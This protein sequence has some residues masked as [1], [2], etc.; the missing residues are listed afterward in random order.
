MISYAKMGSAQGAAKY[1]TAERT[2]ARAEYYAKESV[3]SVWG[4]KGSIYAG[5]DIGSEVNPDKFVETLEGRM[6][7]PL[8]GEIQQLGTRSGDGVLHRPGLDLTFSAPKSVSVIG[9]VG[10]DNRI[11]EA[12][13]AAVDKGMRFLES[14]AS[15]RVRLDNK[16]IEYRTTENLLYAKFQHETSRA[17]DP[18]LHTHVAV[19][20]ATF[21]AKSGQWRSLEYHSVV[22]SL[23]AADAIYKNELACSLKELGYGVRWTENGPE[24]DGVSREQIEA[25]SKRTADID[26]SLE[27][28]GLSREEA[29]AVMRSKAAV[30][31]RDQK[32]HINRDELANRWQQEAKAVGLHVDS[33]VKHFQSMETKA[34]NGGMPSAAQAVDKAIAHL[35]ERDQ[36]FSK[37]DVVLHANA[38][39]HGAVSSDQ[40]TQAIA[41]SIAKGSLLSKGVDAQSGL[42]VVTTPMA[43]QVERDQAAMILAGR[44]GVEPIMLPQ[45]AGLRL[46]HADAHREFPMDDG[47]REAATMILSTMDRFVGVQ[48][49]A[50]AGKTTMLDT[51]KDLAESKGYKVIG[52]ANGAEQ[53]AKLQSATGIESQTVASFLIRKDGE[54]NRK[55]E[56]WV[57][58]EAGQVSQKDWNALQVKALNSGARIVFV[59]DKEQLQSVGAGAAFEN[60]QKADMQ[61]ATLSKIYR[62]KDGAGQA[63]AVDLVQG[64]HGDAFDKI[65]SVPGQLVEMRQ[66][67]DA[68]KS[69]PLRKVDQDA[70]KQAKEADSRAVVAKTAEIYVGMKGANTKESAIIFTATNQSR[71]EINEAVRGLMKRESLLGEKE[72]AVTS[73]SDMKLTDAQKKEAWRYK[74]GMVVQADRAYKSMKVGRG[75]QFVVRGVD[76]KTNTVKLANA[77]TGRTVNI[78]PEKKTGFSLYEVSKIGVSV[79]DEIRFTKN[80]QFEGVQNGTKGVVHAVDDRAFIVGVGDKLITLTDKEALHLQHSYAST[81]YKD[82]GNQA[83]KGIYVIDTLKAGGIGRRDA[84]VGMTRATHGTIIVTNDAQ[85]AKELV[86]REQN[87][88]TALGKHGLD[89]EVGSVVRVSDNNI[90]RDMG[91]SLGR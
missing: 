68:L 67:V 60:A 72:V 69:D 37:N 51:V 62:Q 34:A 45:E 32:T 83:E 87:A 26:A 55:N 47:Q 46:D 43:Q 63:A 20:N 30:E 15:S 40:I 80:G 11:L 22:R 44:F 9:L 73:L 66:A 7:N 19:A 23:K 88:T 41:E 24:I 75:D 42:E 74:E 79:G 84:Y 29:S 53:A 89:R 50:G 36:A 56:I 1:L 82:Q 3:Q 28:K 27:S 31:T 58:D 59:G 39:S 91:F 61:T 70:I 76:Q 6:L 71:I 8:T 25:F 16:S 5:I 14:Q 33:L 12:H 13:E 52:M 49:Y 21:D 85:Q 18:Q 57:V 35:S 10:Q 81:T 65:A 48:G 77:Q 64:R 86:Q 90:G 54:P 17:M 2:D 38:F 78:N 4:G